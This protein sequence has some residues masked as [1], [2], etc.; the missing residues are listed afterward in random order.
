MK[1]VLAGMREGDVIA[2]RRPRRRREREGEKD[3][4]EKRRGAPPSCCH[5]EGRF[6]KKPR[7]LRANEDRAEGS[8]FRKTAKEK[9]DSSSSRL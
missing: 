1:L 6:A 7:L 4:D 9:A 2:N 8:A 5:H 3:K